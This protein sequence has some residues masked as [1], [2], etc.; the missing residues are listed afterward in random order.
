MKRIYI[1]RRRGSEG[2]TL[3]ETAVV[4]PVFIV[5]IFGILAFGH[6]QMV[7][8]SIKGA[9]RTAARYG[10]TEGISTAQAEARVRLVMSGGIDPAIVS[11]QIKDAS[12]YDNGGA[13]PNTAT[14]MAALPNIELKTA[15]SRQLFM[16]R[17]AVNYNDVAIVPVSWLDGVQLSGQ[18]FMRHE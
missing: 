7:A 14:A 10:A 13:F 17:A 3:V 18:A 2:T 9:T 8:N 15:D 11:V 5:F 1:G 12:A 16:V 6:A 4:L